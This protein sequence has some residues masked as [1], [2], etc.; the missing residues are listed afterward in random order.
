VL[1]KDFEPWSEEHLSQIKV[2]LGILIQ[3]FTPPD[4]NIARFGRSD[5]VPPTFATES[6]VNSMPFT[7][8]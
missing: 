8:M 3:K 2:E 6:G 5:E 1:Q 4:S 7:V